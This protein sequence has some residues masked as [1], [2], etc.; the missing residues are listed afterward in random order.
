MKSPIDIGKQLARQWHQSKVRSERLLTPGCW[1]LQLPIGKPSAKIFTANTQ[2]VQRHVEVWRQVS[3][4][5]VEWESV[6]YRASLTPVSI[7]VRWCLRTPSEWINAASNL[8]VSQ[9]FQQLEQLVAQV[10]KSFHA[11]LINQ[12]ALWLHKDPHEVITAANLA[13][14]LTPGCAQG[15]PLRLL[16]ESGVDTKFFERNYSLL[17]KLLDERFEGEASGQGLATF[18]DAFEESSHW[19][20]VTPLA[21]G[22]LPF[23]MSKVTTT[24]LASVDLPCS[25]ILIVENEHCIHQL[26]QLPDT[27]AIL[28]SG[29]DLQWLISPNLKSKSIGYWGDMDTWGLLMLARARAFQPAITA[30]LMGRLL[31]EHYASGSAVAEPVNAQQAVPEGLHHHEADFYRYLLSQPRGRLEQEYLPRGVVEMALTEWV[32]HISL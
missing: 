25:R 16:S 6:S 21:P 7:P 24:E 15:R 1:P 9:E 28:G 3:I 13:C 11:L 4:G 20:L 27:I 23:N 31:F 26:P 22:I 8:Q 10:D 5:L 12:R 2:V 18:L 17:T 14:K 29:L 19:V 30:L 32:G